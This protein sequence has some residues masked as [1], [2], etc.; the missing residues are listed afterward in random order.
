MKEANSTG[1]SCLGLEARKAMS[2]GKNTEKFYY[3]FLY[4]VRNCQFPIG[5]CRCTQRCEQN[6]E[7][8]GAG[9]P[10]AGVCGAGTPIGCTMEAIPLFYSVEEIA[11]N[12]MG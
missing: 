5:I 3:A 1:V 7:E 12:N 8:P 2:A 4:C 9:N 6:S 10:H 11:A